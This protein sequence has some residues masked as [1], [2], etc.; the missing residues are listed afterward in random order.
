L[1]DL[2]DADLESLL[3]DIGSLDASSFDEPQ[4]VMPAIGASQGVQ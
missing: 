2:S 4:E 3:G 1:S